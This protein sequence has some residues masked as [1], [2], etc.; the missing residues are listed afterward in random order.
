L[1]GD[2]DAEA[3]LPRLGRH[4]VTRHNGLPTPVASRQMLR[5]L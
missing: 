3:N 4:V 1:E 2:A 5:E